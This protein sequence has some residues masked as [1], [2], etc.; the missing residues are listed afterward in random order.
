[1]MYEQAVRMQRLVDD[2]LS[3]SKLELQENSPP[4]SDCNVYQRIDKIVK[5]FLPLAKKY[6]VKLINNLPLNLSKI[7]GDETQMQ[8]LYS[9]LIE[10]NQIII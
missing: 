5:S 9:N 6:K 7:I 3:L 4:S 8:Q 10:E 1:M 2:L